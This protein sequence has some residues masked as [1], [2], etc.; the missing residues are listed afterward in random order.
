MY[1]GTIFERRPNIILKITKQQARRFILAY[2][3][4]G[5]TYQFSGKQGVLD[6][7]RRVGCI[8]F[9][10]LNIV[11]RNPE[12]VLQARVPDFKPE[13]LNELLYRERRLLDGL[14][15]EM[16]IYPV[17][18]WPYFRRYREAARQRLG[19]SIR[20]IM[21]FL[22]R[23]RQEIV[24]RGPLS[25]INLDYNQIVNWPWAPTRLSRAA[26]ESMYL[27][28]ELIIHH[29]VNTR[30]VYDFS[31]HHIPKELL[32]APDPNETV[33]QYH[34]W[35]V[36]RRIGAVGLMWGKAGDAWRGSWTGVH[37]LKSTELK[38]SLS[39]LLK[40]GLIKEVEIEGIN[41]P[42]FTKTAD[43]NLLKNAAKADNTFPRAVI[44]APLDN[45]LWDRNMV[46]ELFDFEYRWEVYK[47]VAERQYG[48]Y[49]LPVLYDNQFIARFEPGKEP[50]GK[51]IIIKNW[52]W[53]NKPKPSVEMQQSLHRCFQNFLI[54]LGKNKLKIDK[55]SKT[56]AE[57]EFVFQ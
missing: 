24:N 23:I 54:Y 10:A 38:A 43:N 4:L 19:D 15:K 3:G 9:D 2:Q 11:G 14:D 26:L 6:Y 34:D 20:P 28:G 13:M 25:S 8:Q 50:A 56:T 35:Y 5:P 30:K 31:Y 45:L 40:K 47:P 39:R 41:Y 22:P 18:D 53:E 55:K 57:L 36:L 29:K 44:L 32:S 16:C 46:K 12:L 1:W 37:G 49:V 51:D 7:I 27:W 21:P 33:E 48:Y 17:E 52:W 42:L